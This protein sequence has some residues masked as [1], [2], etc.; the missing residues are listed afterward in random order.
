MSALRRSAEQYL[1][2]R[3]ALGYKLHGEGRLL[4]HFVSYL[5]QQ[6]ASRI[7]TELALAWAKQPAHADP[8]WWAKRLSVVRVFARHLATLDPDTDVPPTDLLPLRYRRARP[9]LYSRADIGKLIGA[10]G[11]LVPELRAATYATL[12][13]LLAVTGL[14][15]GEAMA[16]DRDDVDLAGGLLA[17]RCSKFKKSREVA[18]HHS[19][20]AALRDYAARRDELC[21]DTKGPSFFVSMAGT[22]LNHHNTS[23]TFARLVATASLEPRSPSCRP[24]LH[25]LRHSFAVSTL[26]DWHRSGADVQARLPLL[27]TYLGHVNPATTYWYLEAAPELLA[28][29]AERLEHALGQRP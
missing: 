21:P 23:T 1:A 24:R 10:A 4:G 22:R 6:G 9:Y 28:V 19:S 29:A 14:R 26:L 16:L 13:G 27:S 7:T 8:S 11:T 3:R 25:D 18:L 12:V 17:V 15:V 5:E 20:V 2:M